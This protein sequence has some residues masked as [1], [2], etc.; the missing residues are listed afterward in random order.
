MISGFIALTTVLVILLTPILLYLLA[1]G[2]SCITWVQRQYVYP[3][4]VRYQ[5]EKNML[6]GGLLII[7]YCI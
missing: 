4:L 7:G 1:I 5:F 3:S 2:I 6:I